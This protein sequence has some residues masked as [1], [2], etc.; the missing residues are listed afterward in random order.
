MGITEFALIEKY[1]YQRASKRKDVILG[2][3]DDCAL[4]SCP[5]GQ[6]LAMTMDTLVEGVH[7]LP[8]TSA[9]D[10][11]W[12]AIAVN[13]SDL[14]AMGAEPAWLT[15]GLTLPE[16]NKKWLKAFS[17]SF[18]DCAAY[19]GL[20][21]IG[22]DTTSGPLTV[23]IQA[24]G[25][26]PNEAALK[27]SGAKPGDVICV[28]GTLGD[29]GFGL[30]LASGEREIKSKKRSAHFLNRYNQPGPRVAAGIALRNLATS[31]IDISDGLVGDLNH[32]LK[33]SGVGAIIAVDDLPI[34]EPLYAECTQ[35]QAIQFA[36]SAGD[37][38]E[39]CFTAAEDDLERLDKALKTTGCVY[40]PIGR[41]IG[42]NKIHY[43]Q[44]G[45]T[46]KMNNLSAYEH[47]K[48]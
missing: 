37:D 23:T 48:Q 42:G 6:Q 41:I 19:Y 9:E 46:I 44:N 29:A 39:L 17:D 11:A 30:Q 26:V 1:F 25:F 28:T 3:G 10:L 13:L 12:K 20:Q 4:L 8:S 5:E 14:A 18:F 31:A 43:T 35:Q 16:T 33:A 24:T 7:F 15:L 27:R 32:I 21:L 22:G 36:L 40:T 34:S 2:I 45:E 38:Y 47:F